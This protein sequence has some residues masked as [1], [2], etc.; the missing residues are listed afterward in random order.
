MSKYIVGRGSSGGS[1]SSR[2]AVEDANS[3]RSKSYAKIIDM[4]GEG[5]WEEVGV[6]GLKGIYLDDVPIQNADGTYNHTGITVDTRNGAL[7]QTR[8][9]IAD[10]TENA[11]R[12]GTQMVYNV[13]IEQTVFGD[14]L[15]IIR[16]SVSIPT[17]SSTDTAT[18]DTHGSSVQY[19]VEW[20]SVSTGWVEAAT[21]TVE[22][23]CTS[24]Y[25]RQTSFRVAGG[26][27]Y[28]V[29]VTRLTA[30][31]TTS[32]LSNKTYFTAIAAVVEEKFRYP[33]SVLVGLS[34]DA[35][36]FSSIP[37]RAYKCKMLRIKIPT[38]YD[39]ITRIY[40]GIWDGSFKVA[41]SNNP[42]WCFYDLVTNKRYGLGERIPESYVDKWE[43]YTIAQY[44]DELVPNPDGTFEPRFTCNVYIATLAE[45]YKVVQDMVT[46]FRGI[47][48]WGNG[49]IVPIQ[50]GPKDVSY[51]FNNANVSEEGFSYQSSALSTRYNTVKVKWNN[52][53]DFGRQW[54]EY[55]EDTEAI[56]AMGYVNDT[57]IT[58]FGCTSQ[59]MAR[60]IGKW[61]LYTNTYETEAVS[62]VTGQDGAIPRP[63]D[64]IQISDVLRSQERRGGRIRAVAGREVTLD[65]PMDFQ[66]GVDYTFSYIDVEGQSRDIHFAEHGEYS[67]ITMGSDFVAAPAKDSIFIISDDNIPASLYKVVSIAEKDQYQYAIGAVSYNPS[68]YG[69][70]ERNEPLLI[71]NQ[72]SVLVHP[73]EEVNTREVLYADGINVKSKVEIS[74]TAPKFAAKYSLYVIYPDGRRYSTTTTANF[75]ELFDTTPGEH[76]FSITAINLLGQGSQATERGLM[77]YG[78]TVAPSAVTGLDIKAFN[79]QALIQWTQHSDLDVRVGG[80]I[81]LRHTTKDI[82]AASWEDGLDMGVALGG[83]TQFTGPLLLGTYMAKALDSSGLYSATTY[84]SSATVALIQ[85]MNVLEESSEHPT[86]AGAK[87]DL[88]V[89][90]GALTLAPDV[91]GKKTYGLYTFNSSVDLGKALTTRANALV[92]AYAAN[93]TDLIDGR[94]LPFDE[95]E[96]FDG[97]TITGYAVTLSI[98][99]TVDNPV[100]VGAV[101]TDWQVFTI[102]DYYARAFK[103]KLELSTSDPQTTVYVNQLT[104]SLDVPDRVDGVNDIYIGPAGEDIVFTPAFAETPAVAIHIDG[105]QTGDF[106]TVTNKSPTGFTVVVKNAAGTAV[107]RQIDWIAKG[108]GYI[109]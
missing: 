55:V 84:V 24:T 8:M 102:S 9:S 69:F 2:T 23:K 30:D 42:A 93:I 28:T 38:N 14:S 21:E 94:P 19:K 67:T 50:E 68:K 79:N 51:A 1:Q 104:V 18:G 54:I 43:L 34:V 89:E 61:L 66:G 75:V 86:F 17:L 56:S 52:P 101:W 71:T 77:V 32:Y 33:G 99:T 106:P 3:L 88:V 58:A 57:A 25:E 48:Y 29:R 59:G 49:S 20:K 6:G 31:S 95:W 36:Q 4:L 72:K 11:T 63:G 91:D 103:F 100:D 82:G 45:A 10:T 44:C 70:I 76:F 107:A 97:E 80:N 53:A 13:P 47:T 37:T 62:F 22:G 26:S 92:T 85:S 64:V 15:D 35:E 105:M 74:W 90:G 60:R 39:P 87:T 73:V 109:Q 27:P 108:Y 46:V 65:A 41:W 7:N 78:K 96:L 98:S 12:V 40:T 5:E 81:I 83:D 16:V